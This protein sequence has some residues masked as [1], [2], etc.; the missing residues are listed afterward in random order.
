[1]GEPN[2]RQIFAIKRSNEAR[3]RELCADVRENSG[4][5][6][7]FRREDGITSFYAGQAVNVLSR[8][9][10]H[11]SG[12][13]QWI[14]LSIK[15]HGLYDA[16]KKPFGWQVR[17]E[18]YCGIDELDAR[19][20]EVIKKYKKMGWQSRNDMTGSQ[21]KGRKLTVYK[22]RKGYRQGVAYGV[23]K[24]AKHIIG[25]LAQY[26]EV[27]PLESAFVGK[28]LRKS[29]DEIVQKIEQEKEKMK[30]EGKE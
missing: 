30:K 18:C 10:T 21:G 6:L 9:G 23:E 15:K 4:I 19:E 12:Y 11:L 5:Y 2:Y 16:E 26:F 22:M 17:V 20:V 7:F 3:I 24:I 14:D 13:K 1:M 25:T 29:A 27:R 8:L 28:R